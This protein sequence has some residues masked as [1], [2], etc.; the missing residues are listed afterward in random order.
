LVTKRKIIGEAGKG[1][2]APADRRAEKGKDSQ[3]TEHPPTLS[4]GIEIYS[5][6]KN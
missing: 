3:G 6:T 5:P 4:R 2:G 1:E